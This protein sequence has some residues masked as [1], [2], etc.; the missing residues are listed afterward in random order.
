MSAAR[1]GRRHTMFFRILLRAVLV[2]RGRMAG[3]LAAITVSAAVATALLNLYGD[4][5]SKLRADFRGYGANVVVLAHD[6]ATLPAGTMNVVQSQF[7]ADAVMVPYAYVIARTGEGLSGSPVIVAGTDFA[8]AR[9]LNSWWSV[10]KWPSQRSADV[11]GLFGRHAARILTSGNQPL[12]L[13]FSGK[14]LTVTPVGALKTGGDED[15]RIYIDLAQFESWTG[16]LA[17]AIEVR[18]PGTAEQVNSAIASLQAALPNAQVRPVRQIVEAETR[19]LGRTRSM[20]FWT[21]LAV[22]ATSAL[23]VFAALLSWVLD[24]RRDFAVMKALGASERLLVGF[25]ASEAALVGLVGAVLG[26]GTGIGAANWIGRANFGLSVAPQFSLMPLI[27][28]GGVALALVAA[29]APLG[30]LRRIQPAT[31]LRGE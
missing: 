11:E 3:A 24:R 1:N 8:R 31:I 9:S 22:I 23:C 6:G 4:A 10:T 19:V 7:G 5:Q 25:F 21:T 17:S 2:R 20:L 15:S 26:F 16:V 12:E 14:K 13:W 29:T 28:A 30:I 18:V 27:L